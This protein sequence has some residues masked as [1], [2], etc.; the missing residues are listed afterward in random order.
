VSRMCVPA[1]ELREIIED[2]LA[3]RGGVGD[4]ENDV[5]NNDNGALQL[6]AERV[7]N[8][9]KGERACTS[10]VRTLFR[11]RTLEQPTVPAILADLI[12]IAVE[13]PQELRSLTH[14][15]YGLPSALEAVEAHAEELTDSEQE[16]L[17]RKLNNFSL[18]FI[19]DLDTLTPERTITQ[20]KRLREKKRRPAEQTAVAA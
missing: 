10:I 4:V 11:I 5:P 7:V 17:A 14:L 12:L 9:S 3:D 8:A 13:R 16:T 19:Q 18:G 6:I 2:V 1:I 15:A 20:R